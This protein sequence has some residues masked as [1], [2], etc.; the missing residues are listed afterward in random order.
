MGLW[1]AGQAKNFKVKLRDELMERDILYSV[2]KSQILIEY[3]RWMYN[4]IRAQSLVC[5]GSPA[6]ETIASKPL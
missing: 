2:S 1:E 4:Q 6:T 3:W 5:Y